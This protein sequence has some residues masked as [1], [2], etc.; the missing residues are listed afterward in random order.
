VRGGRLL[1]VGFASGSWPEISTARLVMANVSVV[2][3][4]AGGYVRSELD[5]V[6]ARLSALVAEGQLRGTVTEAVPFDELPGALQ[7][8]ADRGV[9]GKH[10]LRGA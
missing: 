4:Y 9:V 8:M 1:A 10:V 3:V 6:H 5:E 2:G 7:R